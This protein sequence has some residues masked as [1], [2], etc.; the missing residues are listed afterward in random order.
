MLL[1]SG[2]GLGAEP[3]PPD[4]P[5]PLERHRTVFEALSERMIGSASRAVRFDW[6]QKTVGLGVVGSALLELNNFASMRI[7]AFARVPLGEVLV[8]FAVSRALSWGSDSTAKLAQTPYR[9]FGRPGRFELDVNVELPL[10]EGVVTPRFKFI[11]AAE[12]VF[13]ATAG[14]RYQIYTESWRDLSA[15]EVGTAIVSPLMSAK[16]V[17]NLE[18]VRLPAMQVDPVRYNLLAGFCL[19]IYFQPGLFLSPRVMMALPIFSGPS[20]SGLGYWW[21]LTARV[22]WML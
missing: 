8:E 9:Q 22:G 3:A 5:S 11:S 6:R 2:W 18:I 10:A 19:D 15:L 13:S 16:E 21:E 7:G 12:L 1:C 4:A 14:L 17:A 20:G